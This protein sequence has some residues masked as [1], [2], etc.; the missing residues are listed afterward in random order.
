MKTLVYHQGVQ[1]G[2]FTEAELRAAVSAGTVAL[3]DVAWREGMPQWIPLSHLLY[4]QLAPPAVPPMR[5][6][7][8]T[9]GLAIAS[10]IL[11]I[12]SLISCSILTGL[13]AVICG[14]MALKEVQQSY[15]ALNG[16]GL[17]V[18][19][20]IM[21]WFS[22]ASIVVIIWVLWMMFIGVGAVSI[23]SNGALK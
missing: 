1:L 16:R 5:P 2:P 3:T 9:S 12:L 8:P 7:T 18:A 15:S 4:P 6:V 17:A 22:V 13:P 11:G 19:G 23:F 21:G 10:L 20:L 14:H